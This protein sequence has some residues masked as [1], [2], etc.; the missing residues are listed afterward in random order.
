MPKLQVHKI[1]VTRKKYNGNKPQTNNLGVLGFFK[2]T[3]T[4]KKFNTE[5]I[6][7]DKWT[8]IAVEISSSTNSLCPQ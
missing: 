4:N 5:V 1:K 6:S 7:L 8:N 3:Q 2:K